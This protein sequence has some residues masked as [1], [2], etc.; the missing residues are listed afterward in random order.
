MNIGNARVA[1]L[2]TELKLSDYQYSLALTMTSI[3]LLVV[4]IPTNL[5]LK[6][7]GANILI[8]AMATLWGLVTALQGLVTSYQGL[9]AA[10]FFLGLAEGGLVPGIALVLSRFYKRDQIQLRITLLFT[11]SSLAGAFSGLLASAILEMDGLAGHSGWRWIFILVCDPF[12]HS[13]IF[14]IITI[15]KGLTKF[16]S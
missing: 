2:Q 15:I 6:R 3:P 9:L 7:V 16:P 4:E 10:R 14:C 12:H 1:G 11:A 5:I 8:P 13:V